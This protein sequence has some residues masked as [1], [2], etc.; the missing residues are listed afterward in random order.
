MRRRPLLGL[1]VGDLAALAV[2]FVL[3]GLQVISGNTGSDEGR[4]FDGWAVLL[5]AGAVALACAGR[6][7][8]ASAALGSLVLTVA[9]YLAGYTSGLINVPYLVSF[10]LLG[11]TGDRRRQYLVGGIAVV[12][13]PVAVLLVG[14]DSLASASGRVD[15]GGGS[16]TPGWRSLASATTCSCTP[17]P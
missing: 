11:A 1:P 10:Y 7:A 2:A 12:S 8:P 13:V 6:R 9:W 5:L 4:G 14:D 3:V 16:P 17:S 15:D